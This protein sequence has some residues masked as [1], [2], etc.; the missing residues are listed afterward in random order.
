MACGHF[1]RFGEIDF[2]KSNWDL[3]IALNG[4]HCLGNRQ[5]S[6]LCTANARDCQLSD[7]NRNPNNDISK[8]IEE[9]SADVLQPPKIDDPSLPLLHQ[10]E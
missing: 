4:V 2:H 8:L 7:I 9:S 3:H 1:K 6:P 10:Y 5:P